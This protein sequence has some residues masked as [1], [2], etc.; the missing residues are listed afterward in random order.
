[1]SKTGRSGG[2]EWPARLR[3]LIEDKRLHEV[4]A[5]PEELA[6]LWQ[7]AIESGR[8][9]ELKGISVD[10]ALRAAYDAAHLAALALLLAHGLRTGSG[11]GRHELAFSAAEGLAPDLLKELV[12][13]SAEVRALR[14]GSMYD[15]IIAGE[16]NATMHSTG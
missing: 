3:N 6:S 9:A 15:P 16:R 11:Q 1:M 5:R 8:D 14:K 10:G 7:K 4:K 2:V 12:P 13:D